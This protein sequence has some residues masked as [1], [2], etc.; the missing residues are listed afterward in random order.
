MLTSIKLFQLLQVSKEI[1]QHGTEFLQTQWHTMK[2]D[3]RTSENN[4]YFYR[5]FTLFMKYSFTIKFIHFFIV[6]LL[7]EKNNIIL[8]CISITLKIARLFG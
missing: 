7:I 5:N 1:L 8:C 2:L 4:L 6:F 3:S